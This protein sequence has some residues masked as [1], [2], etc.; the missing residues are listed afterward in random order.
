[1]NIIDCGLSKF[2]TQTKSIDTNITLNIA[3]QYSFFCNDEFFYIFS[4]VRAL[5]GSIQYKCKSI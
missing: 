4:K 5:I 3:P 2:K 1:M